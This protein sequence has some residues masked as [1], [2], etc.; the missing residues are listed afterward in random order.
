MVIIAST[1]IGQI[2]ESVEI[3][4][5]GTDVEIDVTLYDVEIE[6]FEVEDE[7]VLG[8]YEADYTP[9]DFVDQMENYMTLPFLRGILE[10]LQERLKG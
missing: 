4:V 2:E 9:S 6:D 7:S 3:S 10:D 8:Q 1:T 5:N